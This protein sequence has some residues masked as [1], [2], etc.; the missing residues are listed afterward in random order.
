MYGGVVFLYYVVL[1]E[2]Y[3]DV[4][5]SVFSF[6]MYLYLGFVFGV[7]CMVIMNC[8][9]YVLFE[10]F[11]LLVSFLFFE[12]CDIGLY[13][14]WYSL[15]DCYL[16]M[17]ML[18]V[19]DSE[20]V[21]EV[22]VQ[23]LCCIGCIG[24]EQGLW[25]DLC[26]YYCYG[27]LEVC[28]MDMY[29]DLVCI[30]LIVMLLKWEVEMLELELVQGCVGLLWLCVCI[31]ENKWCVCCYVLQVCWIDWDCDEEVFIVQCFECWWLCIVLCV[32]YVVEWYFWECELVVVFGE[33]SFV[34][35][36]CQ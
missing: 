25:Q 20:V 28:I 12:G 36:L 22:Y 21:Y 13:L 30:G 6:G 3:Q 17:G 33:G 7:L 11:V 14:W 4:V 16:C 23:C 27:M 8:L 2:E 29:L 24:F 26:L 5:C 15:F 9:C 10:V 34:D 31:D 1:V 32:Q 35:Y 19:W 18:D